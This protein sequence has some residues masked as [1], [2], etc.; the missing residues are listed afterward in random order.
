MFFSIYSLSSLSHSYIAIRGNDS[1][2]Y[3]ISSI[4]A[5][6]YYG[7]LYDDNYVITSYNYLRKSLIVLS[8][9]MEACLVLSPNIR[10]YKR[11]VLQYMRDYR[12]LFIL[13]LPTNSQ[14]WFTMI[15]DEFIWYYGRF[16]TIIIGVYMVGS[17]DIPPL[18]HSYDYGR[19]TTLISQNLL[20]FYHNFLPGCYI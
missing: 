11:Q 10:C 2:E 18:V 6:I 1:I 14:L 20:C 7:R 4:N 13:K 12:M 5:L 8:D 19:M 15:I 3:Q 16:P 17:L 9:I